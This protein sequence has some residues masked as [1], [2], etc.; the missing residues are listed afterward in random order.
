M[1]SC[2]ETS[3]IHIFSAY[4]EKMSAI[5][6][7]NLE[8]RLNKILVVF[9]FFCWFFFQNTE[10]N[11]GTLIMLSL[12]IA[13]CQ[14]R[15]LCQLL[16]KSCQQHSNLELFLTSLSYFLLSKSK[17]YR[18]SKVLQAEWTILCRAVCTQSENFTWVFLMGHC[19][20]RQTR[21]YVIRFTS[22]WCWLKE[23]KISN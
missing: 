11:C 20:W 12:N 23:Q 15:S 17:C 9:L 10:T 16:E 6:F 18:L 21:S 3:T 2:C 8:T 14:T 13:P 19:S 22:P 4:M 7:F 1:H 5:S